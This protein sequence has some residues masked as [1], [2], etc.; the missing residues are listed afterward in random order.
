MAIQFKRGTGSANDAHTGL[1]GEISI[2]FT[3]ELIRVHDGVTV[4]GAFSVGA[5]GGGGTTNLS[6][7]YDVSSFTVT[8]SSGTNAVVNAATDTTAGAFSAADKA[9]LDSVEAGATS[10]QTPSEIKAAYES[11]SNTNAFTD[12]EQAKLAGIEAGAEV[13]YTFASQSQAQAG[14][15]TTVVMSPLRTVELIEA[16]NYVIDEGVL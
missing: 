9:K 7:N 4:G 12:S 10:D 14:T 8:S 3:N 6:V 11:N 5:S 16:G 13:N 2:D 15:S 1:D